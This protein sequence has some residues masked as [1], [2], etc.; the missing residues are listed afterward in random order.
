MDVCVN[1]V[2]TYGLIIKYKEHVFP[3]S[4]V[5]FLG[6]KVFP[7]VAFNSIFF[8]CVIYVWMLAWALISLAKRK[9]YRVCAILL[10]GLTAKDLFIM[11]LR[12]RRII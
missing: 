1:I 3:E 7:V 2:G 8:V 12:M 10:L 5:L 4:L 6:E 11:W 9:R